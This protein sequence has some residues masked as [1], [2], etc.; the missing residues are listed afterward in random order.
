MINDDKNIVTFLTHLMIDSTTTSMIHSVR[1]IKGTIISP[2]FSQ[3]TPSE[4]T[5]YKLGHSETHPEL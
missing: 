5:S 4:L 1:G 3:E 2:T